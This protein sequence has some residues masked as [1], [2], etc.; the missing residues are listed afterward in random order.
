[1]EWGSAAG[2]LVVLE[3]QT[4]SNTPLQSSGV[5]DPRGIRQLAVQARPLDSLLAGINAD[6][7]RKLAE[8][9]PGQR[10]ILFLKP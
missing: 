2:I 3:I 7:W 5:F 6:C 8:I 4:E 10:A 9:F 1:M